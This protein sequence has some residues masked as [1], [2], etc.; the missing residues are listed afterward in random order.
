MFIDFS[1]A[2]LSCLLTQFQPFIIDGKEELK[3]V[4]LAVIAKKTNKA[5]RNSSSYRG[6]ASSL[7]LGLMHLGPMLRTHKWVLFSDSLS[8]LYISGCKNVHNQLWRLYDQ[9]TKHCFALIHLDSKSNFLSDHYSRLPDLESLSKEEEQLFN[10]Y[11]EQLEVLDETQFKDAA[12]KDGSLLL[13]NKREQASIKR[14]QEKMLIYASKLS[15]GESLVSSEQHVEGVLE[16][17]TDQ[18]PNTVSRVRTHRTLPTPQTSSVESLTC[19]LHCAHQTSWLPRAQNVSERVCLSRRNEASCVEAFTCTDDEQD[20]TNSD[21]AVSDGETS[22]DPHEKEG[23]VKMH[24]LP[25][26]KIPGSLEHPLSPDEIKTLQSQVMDMQK[27]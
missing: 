22:H 20:E 11:I 3:E 15:A 27:R 8:L 9:L 4:L 1:S 6:E 21:T 17:D 16:C 10:Q 19:G 14:M 2:G 12:I 13:A 5:L 24:R 26:L 25:R 7:S 23:E 18:S